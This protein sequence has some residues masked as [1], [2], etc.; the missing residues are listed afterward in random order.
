MVPYV[1]GNTRSGQR[2]VRKENGESE[3]VSMEYTTKMGGFAHTYHFMCILNSKIHILSYRHSY[4]S[5]N[6]LVGVIMVF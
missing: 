3:E 4:K 2:R 6:T 1:S 5:Y